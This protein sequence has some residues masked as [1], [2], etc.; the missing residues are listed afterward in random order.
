[1]KQEKIVIRIGEKEIANCL[2]TFYHNGIAKVMIIDNL[3]VCDEFRRLGFG[4]KMI[5]LAK[6]LAEN[7]GVDSIEL[8]VNKDN[9]IAEH[10]YNSV[11]FQ[12]TK[13]DYYRFILNKI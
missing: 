8:V 9:V 3:F 7:E 5:N 13:K 2:C 6:M 11:G 10:L 12:K 1:M 4:K